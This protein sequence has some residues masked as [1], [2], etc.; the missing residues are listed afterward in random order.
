MATLRSEMHGG[1][2]RVDVAI[3][4][5]RS[6]VRETEPRLLLRMGGIAAGAAALLFAAL[7]AWPPH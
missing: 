4:R 7:H 5:L 2:A 6:T 1:F 3:E